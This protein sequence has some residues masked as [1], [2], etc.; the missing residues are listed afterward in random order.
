MCREEVEPQ[1]IKRVTVSDEE[2]RTFSTKLLKTKDILEEN[3]DKKTIIFTHWKKEMREFEDLLKTMD[4]EYGCIDGK[5][6]IQ[7]R[8]AIVDDFNSRQGGCVLLSQ[9]QVG[10]TGLNMQG[11]HTII[12]PSLDWS[13]AVEMQAIARAHRLGVE[14]PVQVHRLIAKGSIDDHVVRLQ[15]E[16]L[17]YASQLFEDKRVTKKLGFDP[18]N[19]HELAKIFALI[20]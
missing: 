14:H 13:P 11:C 7:E 4:I 17:E 16:K 18:T 1:S 3:R 2:M 8:Q 9:I 10:G 12:L 5:V 6:S 20:P 15:N 19:L